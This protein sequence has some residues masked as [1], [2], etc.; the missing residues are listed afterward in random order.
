MFVCFVVVVV[1]LSYLVASTALQTVC[2]RCRFLSL[3]IAALSLSLSLS[4]A[5]SLS[6]HRLS[7]RSGKRERAWHRARALRPPPP[8]AS[9]QCGGNSH[10][11]SL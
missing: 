2:A 9:P 5:L 6:P 7:V 10:D 3:V 4:R 1:V 11:G 8:L